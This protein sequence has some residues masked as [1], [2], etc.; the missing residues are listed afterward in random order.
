[1]G[2]Y[3]PSKGRKLL[4]YVRSCPFSSRGRIGNYFDPVSREIDGHAVFVGK[5]KKKRENVPRESFVEA[6]IRDE[7]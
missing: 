1:M 6:G 5:K 3:S 7:G 4:A 2:A